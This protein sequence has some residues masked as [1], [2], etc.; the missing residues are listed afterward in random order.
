MTTNP[1]ASLP[2]ATPNSEVTPRTLKTDD[3]LKLLITSLQNQNPLDAQKSSEM[4]AQLSQITNVQSMTAMQEA[5]AQQK[6]DQSLLLGQDLIGKT[7]LIADPEGGEVTGVV[8]KVN[9]NSKDI[10][11]KIVNVTILG[12][13]Y[14]ISG[15]ESVLQAA[16][17]PANS[18]NPPAP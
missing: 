13:E 4:L 10:K 18:Q 15:L 17:S 7:I 9:V 14:P 11:H 6:I 8:E 3:F 16:S 12:K 1:V 2:P 5:I